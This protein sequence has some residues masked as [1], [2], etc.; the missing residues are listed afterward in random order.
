MGIKI[1][2]LCILLTV[3]SIEYQLRYRVKYYIDYVLWTYE[4]IIFELCT[5]IR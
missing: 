1:E 5:L 2:I 4:N 3:E